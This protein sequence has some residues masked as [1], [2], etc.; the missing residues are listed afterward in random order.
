MTKP[1]PSYFQLLAIADLPALLAATLLSRL[2]GRM[3]GLVIVL[4]ALTRFGSPALAGWL[5]FAAMAPGVAISPLTGALLDRIGSTRAIAVDV[6]ASATLVAA[7]IVADRLGWTNS[8]TLLV[9]VAL[10]SLTGP[11]GIA[12]IRTLLPRLVAPDALDRVN[13][14]DTAIYAFV[15]LCGPALAGVLMGFVGP[16]SALAAIAV[17]YTAAAACIAQVRHISLPSA[18]D[19]SLVRQTLAGLKVVLRQPALRGLVVSYSLYQVAWGALT[20]V[21][22]V[23]LIRALAAEAADSM[24]GLLWAGVGLAGGLGALAAGHL[25]TAGRERS[26]MAVGMIA[27]ALAAWP[28]AAMFGL[29]GLIFGILLAGLAAGPVDVVMLT[30]RQRRTDPAQL[31]RVLSV[32]ISLNMAGF[33]L[34]SALAGIL[35]T[36]SLSATFAAA[37]LAAALA[38]LATR[39]IP[40]NTVA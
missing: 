3:L 10:F 37:C 8:S 36:R 32:S 16:A 9:L 6:V 33:P 40:G 1:S 30:L 4:Y 17:T 18:G 12:G 5:T 24:V 15:D 11:L 26:I 20:I 23:F 22:P 13:A 34:G 14:L 38:A 39:L 29:P 21:V 28:V 19:R 7:M 27:T 2:A 31:G 35:V 25:R